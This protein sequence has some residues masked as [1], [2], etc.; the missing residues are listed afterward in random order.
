MLLFS[1]FL[2]IALG[3]IIDVSLMFL[4]Q[5]NRQIHKKRKKSKE[6]MENEFW[7]KLVQLVFK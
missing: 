4:M 5:I 3:L 6:G 2:L 7:T 1:L